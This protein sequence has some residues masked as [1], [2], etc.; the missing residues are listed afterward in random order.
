MEILK[1]EFENIVINSFSYYDV[2]ETHDEYFYHAFVLGLLTS[3]N[4]TVESNKEYGYGRPD[5]LGYNKDY[6]FVFEL[7]KCSDN[8]D[9]MIEQAFNQIEEK[10]Y[11]A[12]YMDRKVY[13]IVIVFNG[14][15]CK[16]E[17]RDK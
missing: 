15:K 10:K 8:I 12:K 6:C 5:I 3:A 16:L 17:Y 2:T 11:Y 13:K 14:K 9:E 4:L 1:K 7:K